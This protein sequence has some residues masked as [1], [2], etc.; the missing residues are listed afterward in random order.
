VDARLPT[1]GV[2]PS[3]TELGSAIW[4]TQRAVE[5]AA[6]ARLAG[7]GLTTAVVRVLRQLDHQPGQSA[8]DL[9][10]RLG[11]APQSVALAVAAAQERGLLQRRAHPVHG[12]VLQLFLT[13]VGQGACRQAARAIASLERDLTAGTDDTTRDLLWRELRAIAERAETVAR[14]GGFAGITAGRLNPS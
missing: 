10:R 13:P 4:R 9:A 14:P 8:A 12:R 1:P 7:L 5:R 2:F 3:V 6:D 11:L